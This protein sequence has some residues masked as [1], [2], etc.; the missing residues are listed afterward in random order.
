MRYS[1]DIAKKKNSSQ[2][3]L[4]DSYLHLAPLK[5]AYAEPAIKKEKLIWEKEI[6]GLYISEHPMQE[7]KELM[8]RKSLLIGKIKPALVG[9]KIAIGGLISGV[10]KFVT[11]TGKLMLFTKLEDWANKIEVVVFPDILEKNPDIWQEDKIIM[12]QGK[13]SDRNNNLSV[14]CDSVQELRI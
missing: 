8:E 11:K 13:V 2:I 12:V 5:L 1:K 6:L 10:Q 14:I 3:G 9:Q 4:F 7:Y